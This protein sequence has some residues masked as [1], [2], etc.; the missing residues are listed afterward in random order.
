MVNSL[1]KAQLKNGAGK[2][3]SPAPPKNTRSKSIQSPAM[4]AEEQDWR[5][6]DDFQSLMRAE[7]IKR[8]KA[9][10]RAAAQHGKKEMSR[11]HSVLGDKSR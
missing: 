4:L 1:V 6:R 10:M 7:E 2:K 11:M 3:K 8:D 9:R 5:A